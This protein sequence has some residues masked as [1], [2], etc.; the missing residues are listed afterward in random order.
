MSW[1]TMR[2]PSLRLIDSTPAA[3]P[4]EFE[5]SRDSSVVGRDPACDVVLTRPSVSR[6]H[7]RIVRLGDS[8]CLEDLGSTHGTL[9]NDAPVRSLAGLRSGDRIKIGGCT[10]VFIDPAAET[11]EGDTDGPILG[12][13]EVS[14]TVENQLA[15]IRSEEKLRALL[16]I[17]RDLAGTF[18]VKL[19]LEQTLDTLFRMFDKAERGFVLL[20]KSSGDLTLRTMKVRD[21]GTG[22]LTISR[23]IFEHVVLHGQAVL[24]EDVTTDDRFGGSRSVDE[25]DIRSLICVP[26]KDNQRETIGIL[27][28]DTRDRQQPFTADD[29]DILVA[30]AGQVSVTV[31]NARLLEVTRQ[32]RRRLAFLAKTGAALASS[33]DLPETLTAVARLAVPDLGDLCTIDLSESPGVLN[34]VAAA[35]ADRAKQALV[36]KLGELD[37]PDPDSPHPTM[38]VF[39]TGQ[40]E[41]GNT[42][43]AQFLE[44]I[45]RDPEHLALL[46]QLGFSSYIVVPLL[47]RDRTLGVI[48]LVATEPDRCYGPDDLELAEELARRASQAIDNAALFQTAQEA[49]RRAEK[50]GQSKDL[51]LAMLS[52]ELRTPLTPILAVVS[53]RLQRE[54]NPELLPE[55]EM[56][57]RNILLESR[58]ID[59]LL[60][61]S[62]I[63]RGQLGLDRAVVDV[64]Q[65]LQQAIE[66][67]RE[68]VVAGG[69]DLVVDLA[70]EEH[71]VEGDE[72]R[73]LQ[74]SWNLIRNAAKFTP[75]GGTLTIRTRSKLASE[76]D[77]SRFIAIKFE[78]T[79]QGIEPEVMPRIFDAFEQGQADIRGRSGGLGLGLAISRSLAEAHGGRLTAHSAGRNLGSTF[80]LELPVVI[81]ELPSPEF[82]VIAPAAEPR[83]PL[84]ILMVEDNRD[85]LHFL[86]LVLGQRGHE[87][88]TAANLAEGQAKLSATG[89]DLI[90]SDIELPDGTGLEL[91]REAVG[92]GIRGIA[93]SGFGS[94]DDV[95]QS[96][97]AGF[98][99]H[100][101]KP[102]DVNR[103]E[104]TIQ[105]VTLVNS[106]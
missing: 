8:F 80:R 41:L 78:D 60:D 88:W 22:R 79:G 103:L 2:A 53:S 77:P 37:S 58:L 10:L 83:R 30:V 71:H 86:S 16:Q 34:R 12:V 59:D 43:P 15:G 25:A 102:V 81:A 45:A 14:G 51:F 84:K 9:L 27:Q 21:G 82:P 96:H 52:H 3:E 57:R 65:T 105:R 42:V 7:A 66:I 54:T 91:M 85:T 64:H 31:D 100:L 18:E 56:I 39:R 50:A 87:V 32:E 49:R 69:L 5:L 101:T 104:R 99:E 36:D 70:A 61:L 89:F 17:G 90:I 72:A 73:L 26:L 19:V 38:R 33:L 94:E 67:C 29:L 76:C 23:T 92:S 75:P 11:R 24:S 55:W 68:E 98:E 95:K 1:P 106:S 93:M 62:R 13:R 63:E 97:D 74:I 44:S 48:S 20:K 35:H 28:L 46:R 6:R 40:S 4:R 47:A